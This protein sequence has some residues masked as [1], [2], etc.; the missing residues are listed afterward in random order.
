MK[1]MYQTAP[2]LRSHGGIF[3]ISTFPKK[4]RVWLTIVNKVLLSRYQSTN[5]KRS[6]LLTIKPAHFIVNKMDQQ[7]YNKSLIALAYCRIT[8]FNNLLNNPLTTNNL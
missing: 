8:A 6:I 4:T 7:T 5:C 2:S 3:I 1:Y